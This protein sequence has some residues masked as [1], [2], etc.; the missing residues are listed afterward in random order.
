LLIGVVLIPAE[1]VI[2]AGQ[3]GQA[4]DAVIPTWNAA[5]RRRSIVRTWWQ[6]AASRSS[7]TTPR[8]DEPSAPPSPGTS[9]WTCRSPWTEP[10]D[11]SVVRIGTDDSQLHGRHRT[12]RA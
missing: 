8:S 2:P 9:V 3:A 4:K 6:R 10:P 5:T 11:G 12:M 1:V 7:L